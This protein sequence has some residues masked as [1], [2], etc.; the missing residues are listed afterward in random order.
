MLRVDGELI[1][2]DEMVISRAQREGGSQHVT[3]FDGT[4]SVLA[5]P[6][7]EGERRVR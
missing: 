5:Q 1:K 2:N 7:S 6:P 4:N 3:I